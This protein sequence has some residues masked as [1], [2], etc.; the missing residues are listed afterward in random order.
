M[1]SQNGRSPRPERRRSA[2]ERPGFVKHSRS[3]PALS[4]YDECPVSRQAQPG[5]IESDQA[6]ALQCP[7]NFGLRADA[8]RMTGSPKAA[9][10]V[11]DSV[12]IAQP[13]SFRALN[14]SLKL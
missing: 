2:S 3:E 13:T 9:M 5:K 12:L 6:V 10:V 8:P 7:A 4:T 14:R 1:L 11:S